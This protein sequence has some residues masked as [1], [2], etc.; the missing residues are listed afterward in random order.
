MKVLDHDVFSRAG[1]DGYQEDVAFLYIFGG[2]VI[3][4]GTGDGVTV[5]H[6]KGSKEHPLVL[7]NGMTGAE[8]DA[9]TYRLVCRES[10]PR[11]PFRRILIRANDSIRLIHRVLMELEGDEPGSMLNG[12]C[13]GAFEV[14]SHWTRVFWAGDAQVFIRFKDGRVWMTENEMR[15]HDNEMYMLID[16]YFD[17]ASRELG[18]PRRPKETTLRQLLRRIP[19]LS[20]ILN[21]WR[22][23]KENLLQRRMWVHFYGPLCR[24]RDERINTDHPKGY[25]LMNGHPEAPSRWRTQKFYTPHIEIIGSVTD[26]LM[27]PWNEFAELSDEEAARRLLANIEGFGGLRA[28]AE[29]LEEYERTKPVGHVRHMEKAG[30]IVRLG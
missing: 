18:I 23:K 20:S 28:Y 24:A 9:Q 7:Y 10:N 14:T 8:I 4:G 12:L 16:K 21:W 26:G 5:A 6:I 17:Q 15:E 29:Y 13:F 19:V 2:S 1:D 11:E 22:R 3:R 30:V 27:Q 25:S